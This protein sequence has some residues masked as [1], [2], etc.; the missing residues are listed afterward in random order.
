MSAEEAEAFR[1]RVGEDSA[2]VGG[3]AVVRFGAVA[4]AAGAGE[5]F[6]LPF[7]GGEQGRVFNGRQNLLRWRYGVDWVA[8][9]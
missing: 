7:I 5:R 3:G 9:D 2:G 8:H 1:G 4:A 6:E